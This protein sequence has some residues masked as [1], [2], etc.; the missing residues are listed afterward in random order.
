VGWGLGLGM[1]GGGGCAAG[2]CSSRVCAR[3]PGCPLPCAV[4]LGAVCWPPP[5]PGAAGHPGQ[6][7]G[8]L[9]LPGGRGAGAAAACCR[10]ASVRRQTAPKPGQPETQVLDYQNCAHTLLPLVASAYALH[11]M[12]NAMMA[13]Y[14]WGRGPGAARAP[15]GGQLCAGAGPSGPS[16]HPRPFSA[17]GPTLVRPAPAALTPLVPRLL[18]PGRPASAAAARQVPGLRRGA[19]A[20]RGAPC[21]PPP[22]LFQEL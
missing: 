10:Y 12:G 7:A 22:S 1:G 18:P 16:P 19:A 15:P 14:R 17:L 11:F 2:G 13:M 5:P 21:E 20:R 9:R 6:A 3:A 4:G 8:T